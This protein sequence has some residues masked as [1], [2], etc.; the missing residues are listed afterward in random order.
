MIQVHHQFV[1]RIAADLHRRCGV[2]EGAKVLVAASGGAD[3]VALLRGLAMLA[4]RRRW[5]LELAVGHVQHHLRP[6]DEAEKDAQFVARLAKEL[7][8]PHLRADLD[9]PPSPLQG[10]GR[11]GGGAFENQVASDPHPNPLP[12]R[13]RGPGNIESWARRERYRALEEM[14]DAIDATHIATGHHGDDQLETL[15]MRMLRGASVR[16]LRGIAWRRGRVIRPMLRVT[17]NEV[18]DFL[19][20]LDQ[21]WREDRTNTDTTRWRARLRRDVLPVL[22]ELRPDAARKAAQLGR[23]FR[24][25]QEL[26]DHTIDLAADRLRIEDGLATID[27]LEAREMPR[28]VLTGLLRRLLIESGVGADQLGGRIINPIVR[29]IRDREGGQRRFDLPGD[30]RIEV[31]RQVVKL[32]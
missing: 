1:K 7:D 11:G 4:P 29:A 32:I 19:H 15:I 9:L 28:V 10:E 2:H 26:L 24:G 21:P 12:K 30:R 13:E 5:R 3:S 25:M 6:P 14:A 20:A 27:R 16:G 31:T 17:R 22:R 8:L 18:T 23:H